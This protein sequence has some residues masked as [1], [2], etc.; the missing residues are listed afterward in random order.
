M[1]LKRIPILFIALFCLTF[2]SAA[3]AQQTRRYNTVKTKLAAG[4]QVVGGTISTSDPD[5]YCAVANSG[6]DF[7]W[8]EMQHSPLTYEQVARMIW[9]CKDAP[10]IPFIR[11]PDATEGDIQKAMDIGALGIIVPMVDDPQKAANAVKFANYPPIGKRS[12]GGGQYRAVWGDD[13]RQT[14][15]DNLMIVAMIE[16]LE[17]VAIADKIAAV[18]G[19]DI[20]FAASGDLG[21]FSGFARDSEPYMKL[22]NKIHDD[23]LKA[24]K[25]L[26]GPA[27]WRD[28]H[29]YL[30]F[31]GPGQGSLIS[32]G[33]KVALGQAPP[34]GREDVATGDETK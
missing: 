27:A 22:V 10:A 18:P 25:Y 28:R 26:A 30:F 20:V 5:V 2:A 17:G 31:Q 9:A 19:V 29:G 34:G 15:N 7:L 11:V 21:S 4:K 14:I 1:S 23:T 3:E 32:S 16:N 8:I 33:A 12:Q 6:F 24:G 13:Y